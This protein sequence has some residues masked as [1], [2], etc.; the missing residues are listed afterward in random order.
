[1]GAGSAIL[2]AIE[3][4]E[5]FLLRSGRE[6]GFEMIFSE[7]SI[8]LTLAPLRTIFCSPFFRFFLGPAVL[9]FA[10]CR[11]CAELVVVVVSEAVGVAIHGV[12]GSPSLEDQ[13]RYAI[14]LR[15]C[16]RYTMSWEYEWLRFGCRG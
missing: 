7:V 9:L 8:R 16:R 15:V 5:R 1:M 12:D 4:A 13:M 3:A 11:F 2:S 10:L 6:A 14:L